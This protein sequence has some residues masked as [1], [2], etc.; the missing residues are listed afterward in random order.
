MVDVILSVLEVKYTNPSKQGFMRE[1]LGLS[2]SR[3]TESPTIP[4]GNPELTKENLLPHNFILPYL[5][6]LHSR[7]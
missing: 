1:Q 4:L 3:R 6:H 5:M 2:D 7:V